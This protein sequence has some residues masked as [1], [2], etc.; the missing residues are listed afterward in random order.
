MRNRTPAP[1]RADHPRDTDTPRP[2]PELP[3][4]PRR[5]PGGSL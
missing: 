2:H 5:I 3:P 4:L 1:I